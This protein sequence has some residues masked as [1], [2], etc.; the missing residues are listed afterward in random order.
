MF[1]NMIRDWFSDENVPY[2]E[3]VRA[4][5][6]GDVKE[7]NHY[8]NDISMATF[9]FFDVGSSKSTLNAKADRSE[10]FSMDSTLGETVAEPLAVEMF[11]QMLD[12]PMIQFAYGMTLAELIGAAPQAKPMYEAVVNALNAECKINK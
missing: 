7:M 1:E 2:N 8:R 4:L 3:F 9:S 11:N 6:R 10:R 12:G 5:L